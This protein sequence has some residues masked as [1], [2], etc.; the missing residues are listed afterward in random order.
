[1][2]PL[3]RSDFETRLSEALHQEARST[4][5]MTNTRYELDRFFQRTKRRQLRTR[6]IAVVAA[7]L[8]LIGGTVAA[9]ALIGAASSHRTT[10]AHHHKSGE[11]KVPTSTFG[12][13][14]PLAASVPVVNLPGPSYLGV[15]A[16]GDIWAT[17][18]GHPADLYRLS[19]DGKHVLSQTGYPGVGL[20][21]AAPVRVGRTII[22][23]N[24]IGNDYIV[25]NQTGRKIGTLPNHSLGAIAGD[26]AGGW[27]ATKSNQ[28]ADIDATGVHIVRRFTL[29]VSTINGLAVSPGRLWVIDPT[30]NRLL[31]VDTSTGKVTGHT[32]LPASPTQVAYADGAV[33]VASQDYALRRIDPTTMSITAAIL[34]TR[35]RTVADIGSAPNGQLWAQGDQGTVAQLNPASLKVERNIRVY[36]GQNTGVYGAVITANRIFIT[37]GELDSF[38]LP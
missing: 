23:A 5:T 17:S 35:S 33:Y 12:S 34:S 2:T 31:R 7:V 38:P 18:A 19:S 11:P 3:G 10:P 6:V 15:A 4:A 26:S 16:F 22:V 27:V 24:G 29:P 32:D 36:N 13:A 25:F 8:V 28:V 1:M 14:D 9:I 30:N 21:L 20:N 37:S